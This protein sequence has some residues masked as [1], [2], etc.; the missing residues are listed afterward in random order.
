MFHLIAAAIWIL[1]AWWI[2]DWRNWKK[3]HAT[4]LFIILCDLLH[5]F[6]LVNKPL[7]RYTPAPPLPN[8][9][10]VNLLVMFVIYTCGVLIYLPHYP[11]GWKQVPYVALWVAIWAGVERVLIWLHLLV[12]YNG[13]TFF[14]SVMFDL[15]IFIMVRGHYKKPLLVYFITLLVVLIILSSFQTGVKD[16]TQPRVNFPLQA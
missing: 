11:K 15:L 8:H 7:W 13:W 5:N 6:L 1:L 2:G 14:D 10:M 3:Y 12:Y 9:T 4:I 16:M